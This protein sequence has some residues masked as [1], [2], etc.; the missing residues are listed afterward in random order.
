MGRH[1]GRR[2][3]PDVVVL[4]N[5]NSA[6]CR[7]HAPA[8]ATGNADRHSASQ[9]RE[10]GG[11]DGRWQLGRHRARRDRR[12]YDCDVRR[13]RRGRD[14]G[15]RVG[16]TCVPTAWLDQSR[17][18]L[19]AGVDRCRIDPVNL[20]RL[21]MSCGHAASARRMKRTRD[22]CRSLD[23]AAF[24]R[25]Q[26]P[27]LGTSSDQSAVHSAEMKLPECCDL[28][29]IFTP[30]RSRHWRTAARGQLRSV[31]VPDGYPEADACRFR[32]T[33]GYGYGT[34]EQHVRLEAK[35]NG[36]AKYVAQIAGAGF[37]NAHLNLFNRPK[38]NG[39][40]SVLR[41][42]GYDTNSPTETVSMK[43]PE[44]SLTQG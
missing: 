44:I 22:A 35:L 9:P 23:A 16:G 12:S 27:L 25:D 20:S 19:G 29:G 28:L 4:S 34:M 26:Y 6:W 14:C 30:P 11:C 33:T 3:R 15:L 36:T 39:V 31:G 5:G 43:W 37:L 42:Q 32:Y 18:R 2:S 7:A 38:E 8:R 1:A 40:S 21:E 24:A 17:S 13:Y 41:V 10:H